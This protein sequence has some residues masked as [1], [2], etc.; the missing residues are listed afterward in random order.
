MSAIQTQYANLLG[1]R[2]NLEMGAVDSAALRG[3]P[4]GDSARRHVPV[5]MPPG[6]DAEASRR[7][8]VIYVLLGYSGTASSAISARAWERNVVQWIDTL[9]EEGKMAPALL[10][11]VDG[12][13][14]L[15]GSQYV[16]SVHNGAYATHVARDVVA[17]V[18]TNY[19]TI[20][21]EGGRAIVGKSTGGFGAVHLPIKHPGVFC[22]FASH[23][24]DAYFRYALTPVFPLA[25]RT[26][27]QNEYDIAR[28]VDAFEKKVKPS[29]AEMETMLILGQAAAYSPRSATAFDIDLPFD[30]KTGAIREDVFARWLA[31]DPVEAAPAAQAELARLRLRFIDCG[32]R[33]EYALDMG[34]RVLAS[35]LREMGLEVDHQEFDDDH[36]NIG[37][38]YSVS[39]PALGAVL[40]HE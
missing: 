4:L 28:C 32:R 5:Y 6:Y 7:Y 26:L 10:A 13:T 38:R 2:G 40:E 9:I 1:L 15:G 3:N 34:A 14:R 33:D 11:I 20:P 31:Y 25:Q 39:L 30:L 18:D 23:S 21:T 36:R 37:Y 8:P 35:C 19:R 12:F 22:A 17:Y 16:D 24:G 29:Q 27:E